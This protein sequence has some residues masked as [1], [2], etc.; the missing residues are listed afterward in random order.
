MTDILKKIHFAYSD[1]VNLDSKSS[2]S[3]HQQIDFRCN[4][5]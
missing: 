2:Y 1:P 3:A 4:L 5:I